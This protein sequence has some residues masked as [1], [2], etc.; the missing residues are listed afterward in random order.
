MEPVEEAVIEENKVVSLLNMLSSDFDFKCKAIFEVR[1]G[2]Y[3]IVLN[4]IWYFPLES[5]RSLPQLCKYPV[6]LRKYKTPVRHNLTQAR[7]LNTLILSLLSP[8]YD[9]EPATPYGSENAMPNIP[10]VVSQKC[11]G[12]LMHPTRLS[13]AI[14]RVG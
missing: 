6:I 1:A 7:A 3:Y 8:I 5:T 10:S 13:S 2:P 11:W 12:S 4:L 14:F 9:P